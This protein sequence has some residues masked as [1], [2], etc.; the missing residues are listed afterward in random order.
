M[1]ETMKPTIDQFADL[2]KVIAAAAAR[3]DVR[4]FLSTVFIVVRVGDV[5]AIHLPDHEEIVCAADTYDLWEY[6]HLMRTMT[7]D[8]AV[9][10]LHAYALTYKPRS[11]EE[12]PPLRHIGG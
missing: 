7:F 10:F 11:P 4:R 1:T 3:S 2:E 12:M 9:Q 6:G 8:Q 5:A